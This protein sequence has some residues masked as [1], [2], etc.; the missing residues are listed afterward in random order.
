LSLAA[1]TTRKA[2]RFSNRFDEKW[3]ADS[4]NSA[5]RKAFA[6][7]VESERMAGDLSFFCMSRTR[8]NSR[9]KEKFGIDVIRILRT[10]VR[11]NK[12]R[13]V[14]MLDIG[15]GYMFLPPD[16]KASFGDKV[17]VTAI[18]LN[19]SDVSGKE[20]TLRAKLKKLPKGESQEIQAQRRPVERSLEVIAKFKE[21]LKSVDNYAF[22]LFE[23]FAPE[24][25]YDLLVDICGASTY[26]QFP[27]RIE[28]QYFKLSRA[29]S[30]IITVHP[31]KNLIE[32]FGPKSA[33]A[34]ETGFCFVPL[35]V[36]GLKGV[37]I[38]RKVALNRAL[39][40]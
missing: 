28:E 33:I 40:S 7:E 30:V 38:V 3:F 17:A 12:G 32:R 20:S 6:A 15:T 34:K 35:R 29:G 22:S 18:G 24:K 39:I 2:L 14:E 1:S 16:V 10:L 4:N 21:N 36:K 23:N 19:P 37:S 26:S 31:E 9:I 25:K 5:R 13:K 27:A 11:A 8:T